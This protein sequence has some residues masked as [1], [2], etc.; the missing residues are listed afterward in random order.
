[1]PG[2]V[3]ALAG[4]H[5]VI[6]CS[7]SWFQLGKHALRR[8]L[9]EAVSAQDRCAYLCTSLLGCDDTRLVFDGSL[10]VAADGRV[11]GE[12]D[13]FVFDDRVLVDAVVDVAALERGRVTEGS[14]RQQE[15]ELVGGTYGRPPQVVRIDAA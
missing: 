3:A 4:A 2:S 15:G 11:L 10:F 5:L 6:N 1:R 13:R 8:R 12:G 14:W 7:A 9:V